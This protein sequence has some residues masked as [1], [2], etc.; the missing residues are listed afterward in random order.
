MT[1]LAATPAAP[2]ITSANCTAGGTLPAFSF[3]WTPQQGYTGPFTVLVTD[4]AGNAIA[5]TTSASSANGA[6]WT[7]TATMSASTNSYYVQVA[8]TGNVGVISDKVPL[9]FAPVTGITTHFDGVM[10]SVGWTPPASQMPSGETQLLLMTPA[11]AQGAVSASSNF[12]QFI[13]DA[14]LRNADGDWSLYLVPQLNISSGP[15]SAPADVYHIA[16]TIEA[17]TVLGASGT[18][19]TLSNVNLGL[20]IRVPGTA[21]TETSFVA[22]IKANGRVVLTSAPITGTWQHQADASFC[23]TSVQFTYPFNLALD[24]EVSAAQSADTAGK[25][26]GPIGVGSGLVLLP[27]Q[28]IVATVTASGAD[29]VVTATVIPLSGPWS[30]TGSQIAVNGPGG[31]QVIGTPGFGFKQSLNLTAPTIGGAYSL[32]ATQARGNSISPWTG[33]L[34]TFPGNGKP[35]GTGLALITS[36]P[37][38]TTI[39]VDNGVATFGW[40]AITDAGLTGY[41]V[42]ATVAGA[43]VATGTFSGTAGNLSVLEDGAAFSVAG[44]APNVT[45]PASTP[46]TAIT[47]APTKL[48][49][50]WTT[51]GSNGTFTWQVPLGNGAAPDGYLV[52]ICFGDVLVHE[53]SATTTSYPVPANVL[54]ATGGYSFRVRAKKSG[55]PALNGPWS[56]FSAIIA[57]APSSLSVNYDG[58]TLNASWSPIPGATGYRLVLLVN[59]AESGAA[60]FTSIPATSVALAFDNSKSYSLAV[61]ATGPGCVGPAVSAA[62]FGAGIYPQ[63]A[64]NTAASLIPATAPAMA[65]Y[66]ISIGLPQIFT[67]PPAAGSLPTSAPFSLTTGTSPYSY[68]LNIAGTAGALP[69]TF[70]AD[71]I[72]ADLYAAYGTFLS[73]LETLG[74]TAAGVQTVQAA[75]A[76]SM[77]QTFAETLLYAYGFDG[78]SGWTDLKPGMV[79]RVEYESYQTMGGSTPDQAYLNG[80]ITSAVAEYSITRS[81]SNATGFTAVDSFIGWLT[82]LGGTTVTTPPVNNRKQAGGGGLI[83]SGYAMM[84]QP[85]LRLVYP[86]SFPSTDQ[87][88]TP[89]P[90]FNA[91]LLAAP[92]LS[93]LN[94]ATGNIR[95]G[96]AAGA[97]VGVLYFRGRTTLVPQVRVWVNGVEQTVSLGT[98]VGEILAE[99]AMEP[100]A[101]N[102]P[103]TGIRMSRGIGPALVGSP[104]TYDAGAVAAL[105]VD[106]APSGNAGLTALPLLGGD[107]ID[108]GTQGVK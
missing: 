9:L 51:P 106:W 88:G 65:P 68:I 32:F 105:R 73:Q 42:T 44:I 85:F 49:T 54:T 103:L 15:E 78:N 82:A 21:V 26:V 100:S 40:T 7:A 39:S 83:D 35:V 99:R 91:L 47:A 90:E 59:G 4:S 37:A 72:R 58:A 14:N 13:V 24:F 6:N 10:L 94:T 56:S 62:V 16:P 95:G 25:V 64:A 52:Q 79:L 3:T 28:G 93:A 75:I 74:A 18:N 81:A 96:N 33:S 66:V 63:F 27:P 80:F 46:V 30:P 97:G 61:Q 108:L 67:S 20:T 102:L 41:Q 57:T 8:V 5:G 87:I 55:T 43:A 50:V 84:R 77:P 1:T 45:G 107:Q 29:R 69:W 48:L 17:V 101:V 31:S 89:Y 60:W 19:A 12:A 98:T 92:S 23:T 71:P 38:L 104:A 76:R 22:V 70:T 2:I 34:G 53:G 11:G 36:I 86:P